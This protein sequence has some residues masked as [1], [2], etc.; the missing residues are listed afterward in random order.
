MP[1]NGRS[2][3]EDPGDIGRRVA[4]RRR[5]LG[6]SRDELAEAAGMATDYLAYLEERPAELTA[7]GILR[8]SK[9]L[10][11]PVG[12][13]LGEGVDL[14]PGRGR[15]GTHPVL[16]ELDAAACTRLLAPGGVGRVVL[17]QDRGPVA[18][19]VNFT[20]LDG[21]VVFRTSPGFAA[22]VVAG[23]EVGFEVDHVDDALHEGW[24]VLVSGRAERLTDPGEV[25]RARALEVEPW[26]GGDRDDLVRIVPD[27]VSGRRIRVEH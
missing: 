15:A 1:E 22:A 17:V 12:Y 27:E 26:A 9:A 23:Q 16:S 4:H 14:P 6:L 10:D 11:V 18:I 5:E 7:G 8:L 24:S 19:P 25:V 21:D 3:P 13:L 2:D 20:V